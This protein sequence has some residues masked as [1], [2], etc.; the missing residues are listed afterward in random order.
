MIIN[1]AAYYTGAQLR[2][3][4]KDVKL[5]NLALVEQLERL[6][7]ALAPTYDL[8]PEGQKE[9]ERIQNVIN[10]KPVEKDRETNV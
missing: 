1:D 8:S 7:N 3:Y 10:N 9:L 6:R 2:A 5:H 4:I